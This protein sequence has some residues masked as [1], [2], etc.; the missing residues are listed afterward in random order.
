MQMTGVPDI[1]IDY[2]EA[3]FTRGRTKDE[4]EPTA[5]LGDGGFGGNRCRHV[6]RTSTRS[7]S[8]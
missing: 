3:Q 5:K 8:V 2:H 7:N 4:P 6:E 1:L